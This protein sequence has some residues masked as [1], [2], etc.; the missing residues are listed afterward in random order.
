MRIIMILFT[1]MVLFVGCAK[2]QRG[3]Q[4]GQGVAGLDDVDPTATQTDIQATVERENE[5][6]ASVGQESLVPGLAC[7]LY[8]VPTTATLIIGAT[9]TTVGTWGYTGVFNQQV[10]PVT[11]GFN[12]LPAGLQATY[13]TWFIVKCS[14]Q[15][16]VSDDAWHGFDLTS[17]DGSNLYVDG[18][19]I[20]NDGLHST[21]TKFGSKYLKYGLHSFELDYFQGGGAQS[22]ILN[23]DGSLLSNEHFYH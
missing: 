14:G 16:V 3:D 13:Q 12:V 9:L 2:G 1:V 11:D 18:I 5:Y 6:R 23:Y 19:L 20:N 10:A 17:D 15:F 22:L 21:Q 8:T 7:T 4:G